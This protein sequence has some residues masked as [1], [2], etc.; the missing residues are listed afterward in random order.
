[1]VRFIQ[2]VAFILAGGSLLAQ[3]PGPAGTSGS[4][5]I[6]QDSSV[7]VA[8]AKSCKLDRGPMDITN[9]NLGST[10]VGDSNSCVGKANANIVSLGDG[11]SATLTFETPIIDG[12]GFDFAVFE[13][14][15]VDSYLEL[16]FVEVSSDGERFVRFPSHSLT[17]DSVQIGP[18]DSVGDATKLNNLAGKYRAQ[19]GTPFDLEALQDSTG[20]DIQHIT[21]VRIVDVVGSIDSLEGSKDAFGNYINDP[22]PTPFISGG[23]DLNAVGVINTWPMGF[24][25]SIEETI[26]IYPNPI[27]SGNGLH[28]ETNSTEKDWVILNLNGE[29]V[30]NE[31]QNNQT[32]SLPAGIYVIMDKKEGQANSR[33]LIVY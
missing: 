1:M 6:H 13:N 28:I 20:L 2:T 14:A 22:F 33:K 10:T 27:Q 24:S 18:F 31:V 26:S 8:W 11:G 12:P 5:A 3:Y 9:S 23:F 16:A 30:V 7:V 21:H 32:L 4:T 17:Q 19:F 15:F 25:E 29:V